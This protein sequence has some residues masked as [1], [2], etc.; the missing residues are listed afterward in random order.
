MLEQAPD[1]KPRIVESTGSGNQSVRHYRKPISKLCWADCKC[2]FEEAWAGWIK[3]NAPRMGAALAFYTLLSMMPLLL[4]VI[5]VAGLLFGPQQAQAGV[6]GQL[7]ILLGEQ[8]TKLLEALLVGAQSK[9]GSLGAGII[10]T[11]TLLFGATGVLVELRDALNTVWDVP[12]REMSRVQ[13]IQ[14][15]IKGRLWSLL[16]VLGIVF[17]LT[18]SLFISTWISALGALASMLPAHEA[19][20]HI[21]NVVLS[22]IIVAGLFG[23]IYKVIPDVPIEWPDVMLGAAV[24][25]VLFT[26]GNLVLG[27]YLGNASFSSTYGAAASTIVFA[28][29]VYYSSQV[30]FL[31]A[32]FTKAFAERYGSAPTQTAP[33][34]LTA[35]GGETPP[36]QS[37]PPLIVPGR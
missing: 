18:A 30:F 17:L 22:L 26:L 7:Q 16:L 20:L 11:L 15:L 6:M 35:P 4:V 24:T 34:T 27:L 31:G 19:V 12:A 8:R 14:G 5:S 13:E 29:W 9:A 33:P 28:L 10:G 1:R 37:G 32:E 23:A 2:I 21:L 25:S 3:H 36:S